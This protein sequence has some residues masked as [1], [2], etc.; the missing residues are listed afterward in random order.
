[1]AG[2]HQRPEYNAE[3]SSNI[4]DLTLHPTDIYP[5]GKMSRR[6]NQNCYQY[7]LPTSLVNSG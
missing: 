5:E 7:L 3:H 2:L 6:Y 1:M 4:P